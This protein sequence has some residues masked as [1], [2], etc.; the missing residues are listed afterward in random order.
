VNS[1]E[2]TAFMGEARK[3]GKAIWDITGRK[4]VDIVFEH[5]GE[6]TFPVSCFVAKRGGMIVFCAGTSGFNLTFDARF[7]WMRQKRIQGSHF[8]HLKQAAAANQFVIDRRIDPCMGEIFPWDKIPAAHTK[9]WKNLHA[10]GNMAVLVNSP[11][12]GLKTLD[13]VIEAATEK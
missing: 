5:P 13:D 12:P 3:F 11:K 9:M 4:D 2:Y 1:P 6:Q 7:V 10:P 8:A